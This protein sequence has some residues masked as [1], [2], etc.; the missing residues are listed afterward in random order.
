MNR[1]ITV[2]ALFACVLIP[3]LSMAAHAGD[4]VDVL[5]VKENYYNATLGVVSALSGDEMAVLAAGCVVR[6]DSLPDDRREQIAQSARLIGSA[7]YNDWLRSLP[8][9]PSLGLFIA[10]EFSVTISR[11]AA[12]S[13]VEDKLLLSQLVPGLPELPDAHCSS[14]PAN[15]VMTDP[16]SMEEI[17]AQA[18]TSPEEKV[19]WLRNRA[20]LLLTPVGN[21]WLSR[22]Q[23]VP[24]SIDS[25]TKKEAFA[26]SALSVAQRDWVGGIYEKYRSTMMT[27]QGMLERHNDRTGGAPDATIVVDAATGVVAD[28]A[29]VPKHRLPP[30][31]ELGEANV[32]LCVAYLPS[33]I[34]LNVDTDPC[35]SGI[36]WSLR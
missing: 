1:S 35:K 19:Q 13:T 30:W 7:W 31:S 3:C 11:T 24:F 2:A 23:T 32:T 33:I 6:I 20:L 9:A 25:F 29:A 36:G 34:N 27:K 8:G 28:P 12:G 21:A 5:R 26:V 10:P 14:A 4:A 15:V 17:T 18:P 22:A 16:P